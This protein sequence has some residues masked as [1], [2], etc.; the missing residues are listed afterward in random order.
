M[1][2]MVTNSSEA[3]GF[4]QWT[5]SGYMSDTFLFYKER[6]RQRKTKKQRDS[7]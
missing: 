2:L 6:Q 4:L 3:D 1:E 5:T 7:D